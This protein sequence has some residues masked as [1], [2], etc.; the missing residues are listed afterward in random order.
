MLIR[1][2]QV[3]DRALARLA[4]IVHGA[5][6]ES[7]VHTC[8]ESAGLLAVALGFYD[9]VPDDHEKLRLQFPVYDA[10]YAYCKRLVARES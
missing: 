8:P 7:E 5:D 1:E 3:K 2:Y 9:S 4:K 10:L 6:I